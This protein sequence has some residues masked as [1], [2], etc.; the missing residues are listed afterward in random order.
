VELRSA[1]CHRDIDPAAKLKIALDER[2]HMLHCTLTPTLSCSVDT[3]RREAAAA[4]PERRS[5]RSHTS[6]HV[7]SKTH[8]HVQVCPMIFESELAVDVPH[9]M[10]LACLFTSLRGPLR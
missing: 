10:Q 1:I 5:V 3:A 7:Q 9:R 8:G 2:Q 6:M 4:S